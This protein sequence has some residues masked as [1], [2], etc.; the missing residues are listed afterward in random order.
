[1]TETLSQFHFLRPAWLCLV[2]LGAVVWWLWRRSTD[3]LQGWRAQM[4]AELLQALV[5]GGDARLI[6]RPYL[7]LAS[8]MLAAA[9][10][11]G[12]TWR[13]EPNPF[14]ADAQPLVILLKSDES[15]QLAPPSPSRIERAHLK[16]ADLVEAREGQL[17]GLIAYAGSAHLVLPP[18]R[19]TQA[20]AKMASEVSPAIMPEPGDRL[21]LA[22]K[23]ASDLL[24]ESQAGGSLLVIADSVDLDA[25]AVDSLSNRKHPFP[26]QFLALVGDGSPERETIEMTAR[27]VRASVQSLAVDD[28]DITSIVAFAERRAAAGVAGE[29]SR[30]QE[31]G[32][33][34]TPVLAL[35]VALSFRRQQTVIP[36]GTP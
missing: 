31:A 9:A 20:V 6:W 24:A 18:T 26:I 28:A 11:A 8:W 3:D 14:A 35:L 17:L 32:Y 23:K 27:S 34:M 15:M 29:S 22:I 10:I 2:P 25:S 30:W 13:L 5:V 16:I 4:D 36:E 12:P 33:W 19:D 1:M 7:L 21:D